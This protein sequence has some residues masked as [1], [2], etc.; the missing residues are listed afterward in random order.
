MPCS[1]DSTPPASQRRV[2][3]LVAGGVDP[4]HDPGL[5]GVE[6][7][8]RV[9][10]AVAGVEHVHHLEV[11]AV[12]DRRTPRPAPR[13]AGCGA[14]PCR[15]GSSWARSGR[16]R[17]TPTCGPSTAAPARRRRPPPARP[18]PRGRGRPRATG[19][20]VGRHPVRAG[21]RPRPAAPRRRRSGSRRRTKSSTACGDAGVHHLERGGHDP[22]GDD[23]AH[24]SRPRRPRSSKSSS[25]VRTAGGSGV[26]RTATAVAMPIVP[27]LPTNAPRRS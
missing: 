3:D 21:R 24:A 25:S 26:R 27:S 12:G 23:A 9:Q 6:H 7:E 15:A 8:Q 2:H 18:G 22:G 14:P 20:G 4:L 19:A 11:V 1:P 17:R 5:A 10:V 16:S 13:P